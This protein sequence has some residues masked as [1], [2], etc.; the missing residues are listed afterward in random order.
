MKTIRNIDTSGG[1]RL[2]Y[3]AEGAS[4][5]VIAI[6]NQKG[7]VG[8]TAIALHLATAFTRHDCGVVVLDLDPQA[9]SA[10]WKDYRKAEFPAVQSI[11]P[12]RLKHVLAECRTIGADIV[13]L[14]T[15]PHSDGPALEAA[16]NADL[17]LV[18]AQPS[19]I[20]LRAMSK[21]ADL[22]KM[23]NAS[24]V[25]V[26]LNNVPAQAADADAAA[27]FIPEE[28]GISVAPVRLGARMIFKRSLVEGQTA[29]ETEPG[30]KAA[31]EVERLYE[32]TCH[33]L[34]M[35]TNRSVDT[36]E[37]KE[38]TH[39]QAPARRRPVPA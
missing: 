10:E 36:S 15:A 22:L 1:I 34:G 38:A 4:M 31:E 14:D 5:Q 13:I 7:G 32:W 19:I 11:Q 9:S 39:E 30:S 20:D 3:Q 25:Y 29:Q 6:V 37:E 35:S 23:A 2:E 18:P 27:G 24:K 8:K 21:T 12:A 16:R 33:Q 28:Y 26:V 17:V